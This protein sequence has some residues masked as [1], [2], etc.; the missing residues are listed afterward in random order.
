[1]LDK[2]LQRLRQVGLRISPTKVCLPQSKEKYLGYIFDKDGVRADPTRMEALVKM[3]RPK[4]VKGVRTIMGCFN[5]Y[6]RFVKDFS[7]MAL[8]INELLRKEEPFVCDDRRQV[9]LDTLKAALLKNAVL[10]APDPNKPFILGLDA[11]DYAIGSVVSQTS[12]DSLE[13]PCVLMNS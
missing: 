2:L 6:R 3:P 5:Y 7:K 4:D 12:D 1:M 10:Y 9:A 8:P 13:R 11:T